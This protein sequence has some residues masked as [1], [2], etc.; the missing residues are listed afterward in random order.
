MEAGGKWGSGLQLSSLWNRVLCLGPTTLPC[1][2]PKGERR[3]VFLRGTWLPDS[4]Q[5]YGACAEDAG[6]VMGHADPIALVAL[7]MTPTGNA[8]S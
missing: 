4:L 8:P 5:I 1:G 2:H 3:V 6:E 7:R